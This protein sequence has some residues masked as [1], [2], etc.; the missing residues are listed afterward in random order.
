MIDINDSESLRNIMSE[1]LSR[2]IDNAVRS[3]W[4]DH[5]VALLL[6]ELAEAHLMKVAAG[7]I[8]DGALHSQRAVS[9]KN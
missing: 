7:V 4:P 6:M 1:S 9:L 3:G 2:M 5:D 8:S